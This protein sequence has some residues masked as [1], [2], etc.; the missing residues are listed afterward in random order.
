[1]T[2]IVWAPPREETLQDLL[3]NLQGWAEDLRE[4]EAGEDYAVIIEG[5]ADRLER[6]MKLEGIALTKPASRQPER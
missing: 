5:I 2:R 1:M 4:G 3:R 6:V